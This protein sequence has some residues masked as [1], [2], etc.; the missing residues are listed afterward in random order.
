MRRRLFSQHAG[1]TEATVK[2][3]FPELVK[4]E[5]TDSD[6]VV[7]MI[8]VPDHKTGLPSSDI[9]MYLSSKTPVQVREFIKQNIFGD[10]KDVPSSWSDEIDDDLICELVRQSDETVD[11]Y[12]VRVSNLMINERAKL[13]ES[14]ARIR[15]A[16]RARMAKS[17]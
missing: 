11:D 5:L 14:F 6:R 17:Q 3:H 4:K 15:N 10:P 12:S 16:E 7:N 13:H 1:L 9:S 2:P 8:F